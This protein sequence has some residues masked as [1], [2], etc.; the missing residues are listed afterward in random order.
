MKKVMNKLSLAMMAVVMICLVYTP[1]A[2]ATDG[3]FSNGIGTKSKGM[4]GAGIAYMKGPFGAALN[5]AGLA[6]LDKKW[7]VEVSVGLFNPNRKYTVTG[8]ATP[9]SD[10]GY[11]DQNG[12]FVNDPRFMAFGLAEGT[13]ESDKKYFVI[14]AIA[15]SYKIG[16]KHN[17]GFNFYGNGG[18]N[19][20]YDAKTYQS[21][22]ILELGDQFPFGPNPMA[23][24]T[25]PTG[26]NLQQMFISLTYA[27]QL[28]KHSIGVSPTF[29]YQTFEAT[30][31]QAFRDMGMAGNP[32]MPVDRSQ[33]VTNNGVDNSTGFGVKIG[34]QGELFNGFRLGASF[35]P[36][37]KMT[38][39][40]KYAGLFAEEGGFDIP[41]NWQAGV[42]Y[43]IAEKVT[44]MFDVK[45]I[46]YSK[47]KS[48]AN[49]MNPQEMMPQVPNMGPTFDPTDI[50]TYMVPNPNFVPL[51]DENGAGFGWE[52][53]TVFK[54]GVEF[55][56]VDTWQFR[57]GFSYGKEP[58][59]QSEVMFNILA[60]AVNNMHLSLGFTKEIK[61]HALNFAVTHALNNKVSGP[62]PFDPA[63][64]IELEMNQWEFE[65]G[66]RF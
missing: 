50:S 30:G 9:M 19:T 13:I 46:L 4:A 39:L 56:C 3:Y 11:M 55:A 23:N 31:L 44:I 35:Q 38:K 48:I 1:D 62:N 22:V 24:V 54:L 27:I 45:Q 5:P 6:F 14:P 61:D 63:Q 15:F 20:T 25:Q 57:T 12:N 2:N 37:I 41:S 51:G 58:I 33:Y 47:V 32:M 8:A 16:E 43:T 17:L 34:Y 18:M 29:V 26:V 7:S 64:T 36:R 59:Q 10:W 21:A 42:S 40:D 53:L 65:L 66:F 49:P 28:G 52:D 60:P